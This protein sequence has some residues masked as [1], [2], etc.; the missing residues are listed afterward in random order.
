VHSLNSD[1]RSIIH[2]LKKEEFDYIIDLHHNT[3]TARIKV[4]L[5]RMDFTVRKLNALKWLFVNFKVNR[6]PEIHMVDRNLETI[7]A[8]I[9]DPDEEGLDYFVPETAFIGP[10]NLPEPYRKGYIALAIGAQHATKKLPLDLLITLG[11]KL[12][13]PIIILGGPE[14]R[15]SGESIVNALPE[16]LILNG[17]GSYSIHQS[18]SLVR[19][20]HLLIT[21][22]TGLMHI[23][24]AFGKK[25]ITLWGNTVPDF[26]MYPFKAD[27]ASINFEVQG[28]ACRPCSK[29]GFQKCPKKHFRCMMNQDLDEVASAAERLYCA[30][31][32]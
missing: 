21:H 1:M 32:E 11:G 8:F 25:I 2:T 3:R 29:I 19:N 16:K 4:G 31:K 30:T 6:L 27:P 26:G 13:R 7:R 5:K 18:A 24:A 14:D 28:L 20:S 10:E 12:S 9:S 23:G 15:A 17:C 22:D